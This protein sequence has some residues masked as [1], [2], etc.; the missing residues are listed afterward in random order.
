MQTLNT[1]IKIFLKTICSLGMVLHPVI[2]APGR[3]KQEDF[4]YDT[5]LGYISG[6]K[7]TLGYILKP[8]LKTKY[9]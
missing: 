4:E 5:S 3:L 1:D 2:L 8:G 6:F 9:L 7:A